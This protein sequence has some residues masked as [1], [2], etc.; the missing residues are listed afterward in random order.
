M[1]IWGW[2]WSAWKDL[3]P[4]GQPPC[5]CNYQV[6]GKV[7]SA[8][9]AVILRSWPAPRGCLEAAHGRDWPTAN[10]QAVSPEAGAAPKKR[11]G[12]VIQ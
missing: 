2:A 3:S 12:A 11:S 10:P 5:A 4:L 9:D 8:C 7:A 6:S 1:K